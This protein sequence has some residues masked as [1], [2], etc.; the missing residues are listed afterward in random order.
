MQCFT[1]ILGSISVT[2]CFGFK[3]VFMALKRVYM[4]KRSPYLYSARNFPLIRCEMSQ[5]PPM[6]TQRPRCVP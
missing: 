3:G 4:V 1:V 5:T 2:T 6:Q